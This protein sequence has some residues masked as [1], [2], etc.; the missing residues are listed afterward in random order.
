MTIVQSRIEKLPVVT[1]DEKIK[2]RLDASGTNTSRVYTEHRQPFT[3]VSPEEYIRL[4]LQEHFE[5][6][7]D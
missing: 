3:N 7:T 5:G 6:P 1:M 2:L 4:Q